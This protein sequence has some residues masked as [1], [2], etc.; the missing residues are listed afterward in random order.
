LRAWYDLKF[1][2]DFRSKFGTEFQDFFTSIMERVYLTDFQRIKPYGN[3]GDR[4]CDGYHRSLN[5]VYQVYAPE[6]M[7]SAETI[8][9]IDEDFR[10][11][12]AQWL[13]MRSWTFVHNQWRGI[14]ADVH[15]KLLKL[16]GKKGIDVLN[17]CEPE[18]REEFSKLDVEIQSLLVGAA[19]TGDSV[20]RIQMKDIVDLV[21]AIAQQTA[22][23]SEEVHEVPAGKLKANALSSAVQDFL[24]VGSRKSKLVKKFFDEYFDPELGD[25]IAKAFR[26]RYDELRDQKII[27]DAAFSELWQF[28]GGGAQRGNV[29]KEAAVLA[30]L[31]FLFEECEIFEAPPRKEIT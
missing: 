23:A 30:I 22:L 3:I 11:A 16:H 10:G 25:R 21:T 26:S 2:H 15:Q 5:R 12:K 18:V 9:K 19:P 6:K 13:E 29:E 24:T 14:P 27:G 28:A 31:A 1:S 20:S 8:K 4:K 7:Q 17:W